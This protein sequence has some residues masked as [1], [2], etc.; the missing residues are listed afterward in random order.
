M[1]RKTPKFSPNPN[2]R[3]RGDPET[4]ETRNVL[5]RH[6]SEISCPHTPERSYTLT[7]NRAMQEYHQKRQKSPIDAQARIMGSL[8]PR[9]PR[10]PR[11]LHALLILPLIMIVPTG[12]SAIG[13]KVITDGAVQDRQYGSRSETATQTPVNGCACSS[14]SPPQTLSRLPSLQTG[15]SARWQRVLPASVLARIGAAPSKRDSRCVMSDKYACL[16]G[17]PLPQTMPPSAVR[18]GQQSVQLPTPYK[19]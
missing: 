12:G 11:L 2:V 9:K 18:D 14:A 7:G 13:S 17:T 3:R 10:P 16:R 6:H 19:S 5:K 8:Q 15:K 1:P 4:I